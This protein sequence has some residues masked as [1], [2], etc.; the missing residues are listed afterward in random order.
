RPSWDAASKAPGPEPAPDAEAPARA[1][2]FP[3][4][5]RESRREA[6]PV[7]PVSGAAEPAAE[8]QG[9]APSVPEEEPEAGAAAELRA[10]PPSSRREPPWVSA[11]SRRSPTRREGRGAGP[12]RPP[13]RRRP[14]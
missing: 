10:V 2:A 6:A 8:L 7:F 12:R 3:E 4:R 13:P 9:A 11:R 1:S 5:E 14:R